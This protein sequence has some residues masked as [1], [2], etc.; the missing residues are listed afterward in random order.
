MPNNSQWLVKMHVNA[1][2]IEAGDVRAGHLGY[3]ALETG[4]II[5]NEQ[6]G[7]PKIQLTGINGN[8]GFALSGIHYNTNYSAK[9][10]G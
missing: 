5:D 8:S 1:K 6:D 10:K 9:P 7:S 3:Y 4:F 2:S